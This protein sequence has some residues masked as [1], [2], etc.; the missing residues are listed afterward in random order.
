MFNQ[1]NKYTTQSPVYLPTF[2]VNGL[3]HGVDL[4]DSAALL[5]IMEGL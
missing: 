4:D 1:Y 5:E 2:K 3:K